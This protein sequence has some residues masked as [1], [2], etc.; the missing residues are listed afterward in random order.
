MLN[1]W[2]RYVTALALVVTLPVAG[3][4]GSDAR[5]GAGTALRDSLDSILDR[6]ME[7]GFTPGIAV[8]V[9]KGDRVVW[10]AELFARLDQRDRLQAAGGKAR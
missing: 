1:S 10:T 2:T 8:A 3:P 4:D 5:T 9:V 6:S 7:V